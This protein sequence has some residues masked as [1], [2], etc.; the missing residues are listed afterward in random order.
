[1][2]IC[3]QA[4]LTTP[5]RRKKPMTS[6]RE[7]ANNVNAYTFCVV[8]SGRSALCQVMIPASYAKD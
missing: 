8:K 1:M 2:Q 7:A 5:N 3:Q 6:K 4:S